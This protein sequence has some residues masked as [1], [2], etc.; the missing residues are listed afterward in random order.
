MGDCLPHRRQ[1]R[2]R[3]CM[4]VWYLHS[5]STTKKDLIVLWLNFDSQ[6]VKCVSCA[7]LCSSDHWSV[8]RW[9]LRTRQ[10]PVCMFRLPPQFQSFPAPNACKY[11]HWSDDALPIGR[12]LTELVL[13]L[14]WER[15]WV[16][17]FCNGRS[18]SSFLEW[19]QAFPRKLK[20]PP[21]WAVILDTVK[22]DL[23]LIWWSNVRCGKDGKKTRVQI[24]WN[25]FVLCLLGF[26]DI[27][28][29]L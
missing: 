22:L 28:T 17:S 18:A 12:V 4:L 23:S 7:Y 27:F 16:C 20:V 1:D 6:S 5:Y 19:D 11:W 15:V 13:L 2:A 3:P 26:G 24:I 21:T 14:V 29:I 10:H 9:T 8:L 25:C